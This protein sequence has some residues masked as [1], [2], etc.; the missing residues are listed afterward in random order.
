LAFVVNKPF[1]NSAE[2]AAVMNAL[3]D[4]ICHVSKGD[5]KFPRCDGVRANEVPNWDDVAEE[6]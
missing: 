2:G 6:A 5:D 4:N 3:T 1:A